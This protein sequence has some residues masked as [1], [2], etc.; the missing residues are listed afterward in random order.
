MSN[1]SVATAQ[2]FVHLAPGFSHS[3]AVTWQ[4]AGVQEF[5]FEQLPVVSEG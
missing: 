1:S 5:K 3:S 4:A 2:S